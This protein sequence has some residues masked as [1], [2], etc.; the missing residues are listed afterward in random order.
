MN[1]FYVLHKA[2]GTVQFEITVRY[3]ILWAKSTV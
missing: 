3:E 1:D 2:G